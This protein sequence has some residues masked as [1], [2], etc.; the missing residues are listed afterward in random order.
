M[1]KD[2]LKTRLKQTE[3]DVV[4]VGC[5]NK[6]TH[7]TLYNYCK[8][9]QRLLITYTMTEQDKVNAGATVGTYHI[10]RNWTATPTTNENQLIVYNHD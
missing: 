5:K 9:Y 4:Q 1:T 3:G 6:E 7:V 8:R 10:I 2:E